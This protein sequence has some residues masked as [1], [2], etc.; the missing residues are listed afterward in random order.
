MSKKKIVVCHAQVP[1]V[2]GGAELLVDQLCVQLRLRGY[3]VDSVKIPFKWYPKNEILNH[4]FT[5]RMIDLTE[6]NGQKIDMVI[7]TKFPSY[8]IRHP[9]KVTW[10]VHQFR[11]VYDLF[12]T[13]HSDFTMNPNDLAIR[14]AIK[15][16]DEA[17]LKE[18]KKIF[19]IAQ[20]TTNRLK[21]YNNIEGETLYHPPKHIGKY[22]NEVYG[23]YILSIG[24][25]DKL[26]RIDLLVEAMKYTPKKVKC[27]IGG[28]GPEE[29]QLKKM[30][31][32]YGLEDRV[33]FLGFVDDQKLLELYAKCFSVY[34]APFDEDY[35]YITLE[36][37]LSKKPVITSQ[38]SGGVLEFVKDG[39]NGHISAPIPEKI[40]E[41]I[42]MLYDKRHSN[43]VDMGQEGYDLVKFI[44]WDYAIDK[45]TETLK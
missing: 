31:H 38:D 16:F 29:D 27:L 11:Q 7:G 32:K 36:A 8:G 35:G 24:R 10:L 14:E 20:N 2:N 9:N 22:Y 12:N 4:A 21:N 25:L 1:F 45:L 30:V 15:K 43:T 3:N 28:T 34:Y 26:K 23:D 44:T 37:F 33:H 6:S 5:W 13:A 19:T 17:T 18:S 39:I 41:K 40:A 42:M